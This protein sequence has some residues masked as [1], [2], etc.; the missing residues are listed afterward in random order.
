MM[1][2]DLESQYLNLFSSVTEQGASSSG[3][4]GPPCG[5]M[6]RCS[7]MFTVYLKRHENMK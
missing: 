6:E 7:H 5:R 1:T 2:T 4:G 3:T